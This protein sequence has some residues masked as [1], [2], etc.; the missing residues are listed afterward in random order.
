M[1]VQFP[2]FL[3]LAS[4]QMVRSA[5]RQQAGYQPPETTDVFHQLLNRLSLAEN[6]RDR[7][8]TGAI[9]LCS[10]IE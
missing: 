10:E 6:T 5:V 4:S 7:T 2:E 9:R 1:S 3:S 8:D